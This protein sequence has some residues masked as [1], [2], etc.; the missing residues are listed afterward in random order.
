MP[1]HH[2]PYAAP[3]ADNSSFQP[4]ARSRPRA[5]ADDMIETMVAAREDDL[6]NVRSL[7]HYRGG[8]AGLSLLQR[9]QSLFRHLSG[10]PLSPTAEGLVDD[11]VHTFDFKA[12]SSMSTISWEAF[13]LLPLPKAMDHA[14]DVVVDQAQ[15]GP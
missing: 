12:P 15:T 7:E 9:G 1:G 4:S 8:F 6:V 2:I 3:Q 10:M 5:S 13:P 11:F 14:I